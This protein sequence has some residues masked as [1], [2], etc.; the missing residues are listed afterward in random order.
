MLK[1]GTMTLENI[2]HNHN[3]RI[4]TEKINS[5]FQSI[6]KVEKRSIVKGYK[7]HN[8][9]QFFNCSFVVLH[10][11]KYVIENSILYKSQVQCH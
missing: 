5:I 6:N 9:Q 10:T 4:N 7:R 8:G 2:L 11:R 3:G 1:H